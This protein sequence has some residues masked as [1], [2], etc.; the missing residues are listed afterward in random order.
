VIRAL[1]L[2]AVGVGVWLWAR[3]YRDVRRWPADLS[4]EAARV[5]EA[6]LEA[7]EAGRRAAARRE[8]EIDR[9]LSSTGP[10]ARR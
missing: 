4:V 3:G 7:L 10:P 2:G 8:A 9:E 1:A 5:R 6:A